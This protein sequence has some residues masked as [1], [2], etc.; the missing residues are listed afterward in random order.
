M[1]RTAAST[2]PPTIVGSP[3]KSLS[4]GEWSRVGE[5]VAKSGYSQHRT[6]VENL[7]ELIASASADEVAAR[8]SGL[9]LRAAA[10][11]RAE[12]LVS[13]PHLAIR[14]FF[15][16]IAHPDPDIGTA[17]LVGLPWRFVGQG[18]IPLMPPPALGNV[19]AREG[20]MTNVG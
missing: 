16:E 11:Q 6:V 19:N 2:A 14:G 4:P 5:L 13:D 17:R 1:P 7:A 18:P 12:D 10:V 9:G 20:G 15:P 8:L 3:S